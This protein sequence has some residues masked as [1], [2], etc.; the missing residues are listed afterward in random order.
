MNWAIAVVRTGVTENL[1]Q[2][3]MKRKHW[4]QIMEEELA[5]VGQGVHA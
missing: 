3:D 1:N 5:R 4:A 2:A